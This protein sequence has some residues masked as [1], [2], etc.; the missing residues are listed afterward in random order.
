MHG[1]MKIYRGAAAAAR[2]YVEADR[3]RAD[4]Y[5]LAE[6]SGVAMHF[7]ATRDSV[8]RRA[9]MDGKTYERW[10]AGYDVDTALARGRLRKDEKGVRFVEVT[11]NGPKT[12]SLAAALHIEI[13]EAYHA[14]QRAAAEEIVGWL[15]SHATT[16]V[17][18]RDRQ[19][20]VPV[21]EIEAAVVRH[22]TS[23]AGD[24]HRHLH[25]QINARVFAAGS[26]RGL[27]T[28]GVR[29]SLE[30]ING[31]G[32]AAVMTSPAFREALARHGFTLDAVTGEVVELAAYSGAFSARAKQIEANID[33]YEAEWRADH[34]GEEPGPALRQ[35][36]DRRAWADARP[37]KVV[38]TS[39][40]ELRQRWIEE[41]HELGYQP[42]APN[43]PLFALRAGAIDRDGVVD[44]ALV[45]L[46]SRR[47]AWNA[48]DARGEVERIIASSGG[49]VD[50][51]VRRELAEDLT[52]RV[53]AASQPLLGRSDEPEH[54]RTFTSTEVLA[55]EY[56]IV[57]RI[58]ARAEAD[59]ITVIEGAAG[60][61]KTAR[62]AATRDRAIATGRRMVVVTP[63]LKAAQ[64]AE[65]AT[66]AASYSAAW[67]LYQHG[68][69]WDEDG[70]WSR[71]EAEP[72]LGARLCRGDLLVVDEAGM[73]DQ[74]T[75]RSLLRLADETKALVM[76]V[77]DRHQLPAVG[78]GGVLD[79]A[80]RYA[81]GRMQQLDR[82]R[83]F[84]D[85]H[86][87]ELSLQ[88]RSGVQAGEVFDELFGRGE[89]VIHA[90]DA[91]RT[92]RLAA[93][94]SVGK[95][96]VADTREQVARI[97]TFAHRIRKASGEVDEQQLLTAA[98]ERIG[99]GDTIATRRNDHD[100]GVANRELWTVVSCDRGALT[101]RGHAGL[102]VLPPD[103]VR[104]DVELAYAT[105]AYGAQGA[106]V[107]ESHVLV[108]EHSGAASAY[109]GM[110]RGRE[111]NVAHLVADSVEEARKQWCDVFGRDRADLG[112]AH[113]R[114]A[115]AEA[116][117]RY[118]SMKPLY[119]RRSTPA[120]RRAEDDFGYRA[121][122]PSSGSPGLG[123]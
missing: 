32:H 100:A 53:I 87:A 19:V 122:V 42:P 95:L 25:L 15:A 81:P 71:V 79:L 47:S 6:G 39:G 97:N 109:V 76:L 99:V 45:R 1:G 67:L 123:I 52:A 11:V 121:P 60:A 24:P 56:E 8:E 73:V 3:S 59:A 20:Q 36:W 21:E 85:P 80:I 48:A 18:P 29:D 64:V 103:Y 114:E 93:E 57:D 98:G 69:R 104:C 105:T 96:V 78:R 102:R 30:A 65:G 94:A 12:W 70:R 33:S 116:I 101:V 110:T 112:P 113:A 14:A 117:E 54:V 92:R 62:L 51:A 74:D 111:R 27:H 34:P 108:G 5:Y 90:S 22:F 13:A 49:V 63:T 72:D 10:V 4:D 55:V 88:M 89:I 37:D 82:V 9:D 58:I 77:G 66:G 26:W 83:R 68:F 23:R 44:L 43:A 16:R 41:L 91:E 50:T 106:T 120:P 119:S 86:Y 107:A 40:E 28:V 46:G 84:K 118:G 17:G 75:A 35:A 31:I 115:A 2:H 7:A 38:P 61:G